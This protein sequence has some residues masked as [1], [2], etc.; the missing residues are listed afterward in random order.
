MAYPAPAKNAL[1]GHQGSPSQASL[2]RVLSVFASNHP[3]LHKI[4]YTF[5]ETEFI[6][7]TKNKELQ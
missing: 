2:T 3:H 4:S 5:N 1:N 7:V 6:E